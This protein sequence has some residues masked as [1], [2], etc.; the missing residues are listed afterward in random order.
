[1][2]LVICGVILIIC[3]VVLVRLGKA[4]DSTWEGQHRTAVYV[5]LVLAVSVLLLDLLFG[6]FGLVRSK[7][8][9]I[10][11]ERQAA[12]QA[13]LDA[14][15][16][17]ESIER[18][19]RLE[20]QK[21]I[22]AERE[23]TEAENAAALTDAEREMDSVAGADA[24]RETDPAAG[25]DAETDAETLAR[26]REELAAQLEAVSDKKESLEAALK[27]NLENDIT[28]PEGAYKVLYDTEF[29]DMDYMYQTT[30]NAKGNFYGILYNG[31]GT[32]DGKEGGNIRVTA[33]YNGESAN[34][35]CQVYVLY[36]TLLDDAGNE[37]QTS[38]TDFY[39]VEMET[40]KVI[41]ADKHAWEELGSR[42]YVD[43]TEK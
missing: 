27:V 43:A 33:V 23:R 17:Q 41:R 25:M 32:F 1:M 14:Q 26:Q 34:G 6:V 38:I 4:D 2:Y 8:G 7:S 13:M 18:T 36:K 15:E 3:A 12:E 16:K 31:T 20:A 29:A 19:Q 22:D 42:E 35:R 39:A 10:K 30:Y 5:K 11:A 9:D 28:T 21:Q 37:V 24:D 40:E